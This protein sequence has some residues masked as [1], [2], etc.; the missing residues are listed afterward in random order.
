MCYIEVQR[1]PK[2]HH[3]YIKESRFLASRILLNLYQRRYQSDLS[4]S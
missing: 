1:V 4:V 3:I 2:K